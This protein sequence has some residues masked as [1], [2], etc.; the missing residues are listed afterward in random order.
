MFTIR[1]MTWDDKELKI[2]E[3]MLEEDV[4]EIKKLLSDIDD[5]LAHSI[6]SRMVVE[7][8]NDFLK[9]FN[10]LKPGKEIDFVDANRHLENVINSFYSWT[11]FT[12]KHYKDIFAEI[13]SGFYD[14]NLEY[15]FLFELRTCATH[16]MLPIHSISFLLDQGG[17]PK[18]EIDPQYIIDYG[19]MKNKKTFYK[20]LVKM[21]NEGQKID[22]E[23][24]IIAM[25][26]NM[27]GYEKILL[28]AINSNIAPRVEALIKDWTRDVNFVVIYDD[29]EKAIGGNLIAPVNEYHKLLNYYSI[30][31]GG[32]NQ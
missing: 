22:L 15:K 29:Q 14:N 1:A 2:R 13:R 12:E 21:K 11:E 7:N 9:C 28:K 32:T 10:A 16:K 26:M 18:I 4:D 20:E 25:N 6:K 8:T 19:N 31:W 17:K 5:M 27:P 30:A 24:I 3:D 23:Q